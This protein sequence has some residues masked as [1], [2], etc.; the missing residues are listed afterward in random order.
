MRF[1]VILEAQVLERLAARLELWS[2]GLPGVERS[3]LV[4]LLGLGSAALASADA[5]AGV[6]K[7]RRPAIETVALSMLTPGFA[8]VLSPAGDA[9]LRCATAGCVVAIVYGPDPD[10]WTVTA[11]T[12]D[13][14]NQGFP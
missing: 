12:L 2:T 1:D 9:S 5:I 8:D 14:D 4:S 11:R 13:P 3:H 7:P 6:A 10:C